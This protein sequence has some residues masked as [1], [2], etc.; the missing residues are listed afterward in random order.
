[1]IDSLDDP[2]EVEL[3]LFACEHTTERKAED[4]VYAFRKLRTMLVGDKDWDGL[5]NIAA[6]HWDGTGQW[7]E[8]KT[9]DLSRF[10]YKRAAIRELE[11]NDL[12][13]PWVKRPT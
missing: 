1:V 3:F 8:A 5:I 6:R 11:K 10:V 12:T 4:F 9:R 13:M 7:S 2:D